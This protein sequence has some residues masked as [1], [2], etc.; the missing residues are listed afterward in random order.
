M[1]DWMAKGTCTSMDPHLF[2]P[3]NGM[4]VVSVSLA[5][6]RCPVRDQCYMHA[7]RHEDYGIWAGTSERERR[8]LRKAA[9]IRF[10]RIEWA[11]SQ[12]GDRPSRTANP[13]DDTDGGYHRAI[14]NGRKPTEEA[15]RAHAEV[16]GRHAVERRA[17]MKGSIDA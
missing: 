12:A 14:R 2:Y 3:S 8:K 4:V 17:E 15:Q 6:Q 16:C 10:E 1:F 9:G 5:C 13:F 11:P 7:L